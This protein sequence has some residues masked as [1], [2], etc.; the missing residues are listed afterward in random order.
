MEMYL[1]GFVLGFA[2]GAAI[3]FFY[4]LW[5]VDNHFWITRK[6]P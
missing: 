5:R 4:A 3:G 1:L 6:D 2:G